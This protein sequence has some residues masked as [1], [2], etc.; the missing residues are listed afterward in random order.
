[1]KTQTFTEQIDELGALDAEL[2]H[3]AP[4]IKRQKDLREII[5]EHYA[6]APANMPATASGK[7]Y[8]VIVGEKGFERSVLSMPKLFKRLTPSVFFRNCKVTLGVL[9][10]LLTK[11]EIAAFVVSE[12]T[13]YRPITTVAKAAA[14]A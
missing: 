4:K 3:V 7:L 10:V 11:A 1:M 5:R 2:A 6:L 13:G 8:T 12:Q 9:D 14:S